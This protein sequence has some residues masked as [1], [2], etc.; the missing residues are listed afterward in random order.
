MEARVV[1]VSGQH[2]G[3][4]V[5]LDGEIREDLTASSTQSTSDSDPVTMRAHVASGDR[6]KLA[7]EIYMPMPAL[8]RPFHPPLSSAAGDGR[9]S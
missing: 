6:S 4:A 7:G 2:G 5:G 1:E 3:S 8:A 9:G